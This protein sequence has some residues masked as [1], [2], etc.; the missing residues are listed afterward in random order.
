M[1][2]MSSE[3]TPKQ[4]QTLAVALVISITV[5]ILAYIYSEKWLRSLLLFLSHS[6]FA[7][8]QVSSLGIAKRVSRRFVAGETVDEAMAAAR[9]L[10]A[11]GMMATIDYLGESV[12]DTELAITA[13]DEILNL[14]EKI[15]MSGVEANVSVKL[16]QLGL[17]ISEDLALE[18]IRL[19][20]TRAQQYNNKIRIDME[21]SELVDSTLRIYRSLRYKHDFDNVGIVIQSYLYRSEIDVRTFIDEGA[22]IRLC[23]GAYAEPPDIAF[24]DKTDT[25]AN[26]TELAKMMLDK[27]ARD[28]GVYLGIATHDE[29]II[30]S[31]IDYCMVNNVPS[32]DY[33]YQMLYGIRRNLQLRL[34]KQGYKVRIYVPYGTAWY[35]YLVRRLAERPANLWFF[36][37][38]LFRG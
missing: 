3:I 32:D 10:N 5:I 14:L 2:E 20:L 8:D 36:V 28:K 38:N 18:N 1:P 4:S 35:P 12:T 30:H 29:T 24:I 25:D 22:W 37:N 26:F 11:R 6:R 15:E 23:K 13:R 17:R 16:T 27:A 31:L 19:I 34:V 33:E 21:E 7:R 9:A